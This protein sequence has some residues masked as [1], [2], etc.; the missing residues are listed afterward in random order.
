[1]DLTLKQYGQLSDPYT[2]T[3]LSDVNSD[4]LSGGNDYFPPI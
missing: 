1:M 3:F 2:M 4:G